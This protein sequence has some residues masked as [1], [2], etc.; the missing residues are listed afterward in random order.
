MTNRTFTRRFRWGATVALITGLFVMATRGVVARMLQALPDGDG[1]EALT[2]LPDGRWLTTGGADDGALLGATRLVDHRGRVE[3]VE[4]GPAW[5]PRTEHSATLLPTGSVLVI[6]GVT[7]Q[8][9]SGDA[10]LIGT[11]GF[12]TAGVSS[13]LGVP[14]SAH[15]ATLLLDG[16]VLVIGGRDARGEPLASI[17][18][19]D[20]RSGHDSDAPYMPEFG[21]F[22]QWP[23]QLHLPRSQHTATMLPDGTVLVVGGRGGSGDVPSAEIVD[24]AA[25]T[26]RTLDSVLH[27][28]R[29]EHTATLLPDGRVLIAGGYEENSIAV[30]QGL[31][32]VRP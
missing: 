28:P 25:G 24:P 5:R 8:G 27:I 12:D 6:G 18:A 16:R 17:E 32:L 21:A 14:R 1:G 29:S 20:P 19:F 4:L 31:W 15:T 11:P 10:T 3:H 30:S 9:E 22:T 23:A 2:V 13:A 26:V 7:D